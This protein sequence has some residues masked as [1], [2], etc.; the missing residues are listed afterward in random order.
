MS[1]LQPSANSEVPPTLAKSLH[2]HWGV[3]LAEGIILIL[4]GLAAIVVPLIAG[5][6]ATVFLGWLFLIAGVLGLVATFRAKHAPG[7][8]WSLLS[9]LAALIA[10]IVLL[11]NPLQSLVTLTFVLIAFF[12]VDGIL[13]IILSIAHRREL[14]G[15]WEW[16]MVNGIIDLILAAIIISGLPGTLVWALGLLVGI[17]LVFGGMALVAVA[18]DARNAPSAL[19]RA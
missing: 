15:K 5:L 17:D 12:I 1:P 11:W 10:G 7:F 4:L 8:N 9:A 6:A 14:S 16:M 13:I 18:L 19:G 2:D 3:F